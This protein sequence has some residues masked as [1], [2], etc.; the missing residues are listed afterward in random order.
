MKFPPG[1][2]FKFIFSIVNKEVEPV[3]NFNE[4]K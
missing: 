3:D 4:K 1:R 2:D